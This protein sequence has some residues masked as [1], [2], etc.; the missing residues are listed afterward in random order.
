MP[1]TLSTFGATQ[2]HISTLEQPVAT[3]APTET[4][5]ETPAAET[6]VIDTPVA[7]T[8]V[9][10]PTEIDYSTSSFALGGEETPA[11][12]QPEQPAAAQPTFN[13]DEELKKIDRRELAKKLGFNDFAIEI[14]DHITNGGNAI[15]YLNAR[16]IDYSKVSDE[17]IVKSDLQKQYP[18]FTTAQVDLL[19]KRRYG[20][21]E[22]ATEEDKEYAQLQLAAD[23]QRVR[24]TLTEEQKKFKIPE[25]ITP[26]KDEAYEQWKQ[27]RESQTQLSEQIN[28]FYLNHAATK[29]LH[30]NKKVAINVGEGIAPFNIT[31][32]KPELI[33]K[34]FMDGGETWQKL[35]STPTGEPDVQKQQLIALFSFNPQ[36]MLQDMFNYGLQQGKRSLVAEGQNAHRPETKILPMN[37]DQKP[38]YGT[39]TFGS[40]PR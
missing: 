14:N 36:K 39:G 11:A 35:T 17:G 8:P 1:V 27:Y 7:E 31:I 26:V 29:T 9:E 6:P 20:V 28:G 22:M 34:S 2:E 15:D 33:T 40:K 4:P 32:D 38:V 25:A 23:A 37:P 30:E 13:L 21:D 10:Q 3:P 18:T 5:V 19:Y 16:A 12:A 24:Q